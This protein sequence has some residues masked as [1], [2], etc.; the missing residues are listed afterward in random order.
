M[1]SEIRLCFFLIREMKIF[2][3]AL[4]V[5]IDD[6]KH[7]AK[8]NPKWKNHWFTLLFLNIFFSTS[9]QL[10]SPHYAK[11]VFNWSLCKIKFLSASSIAEN[12]FF[13]SGFCFFPP[14]FSSPDLTLLI[15]SLFFGNQ[16]YC[17]TL[18]FFHHP[19]KEFIAHFTAVFKF[20]K[21]FLLIF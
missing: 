21:C 20:Q 16:L 9:F 19:C 13:W 14:V 2:V 12:P 3:E 11:T 18:T 6:F 10:K 1:Q 4:G 5:F 7:K 8:S 17:K 15:F